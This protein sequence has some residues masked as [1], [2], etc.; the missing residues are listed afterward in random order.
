VRCVQI[1]RRVQR[2]QEG[3]VG[4]V[5]LGEGGG[6][7]EGVGWEAGWGGGGN[8]AAAGGGVFVR[9]EELGTK[10]RG[11]IVSG[12]VERR[13]LTAGGRGNRT[14]GFLRIEKV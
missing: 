10:W 2:R 1:Y 12:Q 5:W 3:V 9:A 4:M 6:E 13:V 7:E 11:W 8:P 14:G